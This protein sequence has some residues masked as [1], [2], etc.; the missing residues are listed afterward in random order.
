MDSIGTEDSPI[1][2]PTSS[3]NIKVE[4][5]ME[6]QSIGIEDSGLY[7]EASS[8]IETAVYSQHHPV[9]N[10]AKEE[11]I[12]V[13]NQNTG[14]DAG[15]PSHAKPPTT[16]DFE[17]HPGDASYA[18]GAT[19]AHS[20][21]TEEIL[22]EANILNLASSATGD[23]PNSRDFVSQIIQDAEIQRFA[24]TAGEDSPED[25]TSSQDVL[26]L[27]YSQNDD[28]SNDGESYE[29]KP[30]N[31]SASPQVASFM[32]QT[33]PGRF[34]S[35]DTSS[36]DEVI[37]ICS[38][39]S[40]PDYKDNYEDSH[41]HERNIHDNHNPEEISPSASTSNSTNDEESD[42]GDFLVSDSDASSGDDMAISELISQFDDV[43]LT[44]ENGRLQVAVMSDN[45]SIQSNSDFFKALQDI[46]R[47]RS[48][49][50]A[51]HE[52][53]SNFGESE[54][55]IIEIS[56][57]SSASVATHASQKARELRAQ[58]DQALKTSAAI[59]STQQRLGVELSTFKQRLDKQRN[60][61]ASPTSASNG[62]STN[63]TTYSPRG[64]NTGGYTITSS[65][66]SSALFSSTN[67]GYAYA[68]TTHVPVQQRGVSESPRRQRQ[69]SEATTQR[70]AES[71]E[72]SVSTGR[73]T[74][75]SEARSPA[76][77]SAATS[78]DYGSSTRT[79]VHSPSSYSGQYTNS[80][81]E[82]GGDIVLQTIQ[83][84]EMEE[85]RRREQQL[86]SFAR[87]TYNRME[88][89]SIVDLTR[90]QAAEE[91]Y[92]PRKRKAQGLFF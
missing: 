70:I 68:P 53:E 10:Y 73:A 78:G 75:R 18:S 72:R 83:H 77:S 24:S 27:C 32:A 57:S 56:D 67:S 60:S 88:E 23:D 21:S 8:L 38:E 79:N 2:L 85:R 17:S 16:T 37:H 26:S 62:N 71:R 80:S 41:F 44:S 89:D 65:E 50:S 12:E 55:G 90:V 48:M 29:Q 63:A 13:H 1:I 81:T 66:G 52:N 31:Y 58:L 11:P 76:H 40:V 5:A 51:R 33:S 47:Q 15:S 92:S 4:N 42:S 64:R 91:E 39:D 74:S 59:R 25:D 84:Q 20:K 30:K 69:F 3:G 46:R 43:T 87:Q 9:S 86:Q 19:S 35:D 54:G 36:D 22:N 82:T 49:G 6:E 34:H 28:D 7:V 45:A 61:S 14:S